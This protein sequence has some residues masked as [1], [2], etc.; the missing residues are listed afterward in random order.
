MLYD[1]SLSLTH[2]Y[3][4]PAGN[5]RHLLRVLPKM[6]S[7]RQRMP[8]WQIDVFPLPDYRQ[9][10]SDFFGTA[11]T[12]V[13]HSEPHQDMTIKMACRVEMAPPLPWRDTSPRLSHLRGQVSACR[14]L[15]PAAPVH[16]LGPSYRL[17]PNPDIAAFARDV[18]RPNETVA[19]TTIRLGK[20]LHDAMTFDASATTVD[21]PPA[22][23]FA[24]RRGV[25]QDFTHIM[26]TALQSLG[27]PAGYVSGY[28]RTL[29][30]PGQAR[31]VG[32]DAMHAWVSAWCGSAMGWIEYDPTNATL[33]GT[34]HIV[35][36]YGRDYADVSP[37]LGHLR[38][39]G[40]P[41][42]KQTV[43]VAPVGD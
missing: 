40:A 42:A 1:I 29:P 36:G 16:F 31:L 38:S 8:S 2:K 39:S 24:Q 41:V 25:C 6:V 14:D 28:L 23:A 12:S 3:A 17:A 22:K 4:Q 37:I 15:A 43:D 20:A 13:T 27:I 30:P 18:T 33:V 7:D 35:V 26:I 32:V 19:E 34:D 5:S 9:D 11:L 21:T 10:R